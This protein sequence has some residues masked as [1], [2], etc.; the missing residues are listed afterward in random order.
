MPSVFLPTPRPEGKGVPNRFLTDGKDI[1]NHV[2]P[3][4]VDTIQGIRPLFG[5]ISLLASGEINVVHVTTIG[6][7]S[8]IENV[9]R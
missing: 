4:I 1:P 3:K 2:D 5:P 8:E 9:S 7:A 6:Y